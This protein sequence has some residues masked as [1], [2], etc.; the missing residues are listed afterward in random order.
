MA[1]WD[2]MFPLFQTHGPE[3]VSLLHEA[4]AF[5]QEQRRAAGLTGP[6]DVA[7]VGVSPGD[8]PAEAA[9]RVGAAAEAGMTWWLEIL[10]PEI[11]G[12]GPGQ[13]GAFEAMQARVLQGPPR[14]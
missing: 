7:N 11:Y 14:V 1:R 6:F 12:F 9:Q 10:M 3:Q 4:V 8:D 13:P 5:V 2:G